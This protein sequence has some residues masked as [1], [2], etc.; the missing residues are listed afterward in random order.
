MKR[1][2]SLV[3]AL[4]MCLALGAPALAE[5]APAAGVTSG[6]GILP[7][8]HAFF[9][10]EPTHSEE[11]I[12]DG[13]MAVFTVKPEYAAAAYEYVE[14][15]KSGRFGLA[16]SQTFNKEY[17]DSDLTTEY[18]FGYT[19]SRDVDEVS[20]YSTL[21]STYENGA[22]IIRVNDW[23]GMGWCEMTIW[24]SDD[25]TVEDTGDR[26]TVTGIVDDQVGDFSGPLGSGG[27]SSGGSS[28]G[29]GGIDW[30][31]GDDGGRQ[32][33]VCGGDGSKDC[34]TCGGKG[35]IE[36]YVSSPNYG[37]STFG[38]S[39]RERRSCPNARCHGGRVDCTVCGGDGW[40]D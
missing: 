11:S 7:D 27:Y 34:M 8:A 39:R 31:S 25:L 16:L 35:Y 14:L 37:G 13:T 1:L 10:E 32:C 23:P 9:N 19:G 38:S 40:L 5:D 30:G 28:G 17:P 12:T 18:V 33:S 22:V 20:T 36:E 6:D 21:E 2:V 4:T 24:F 15:L 3:L 26:C 29:G